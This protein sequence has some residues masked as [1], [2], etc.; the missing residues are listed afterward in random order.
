MNSV[1]LVGGFFGR[2][3]AFHQFDVEAER[4]QF[5]DENVER[6]RHTR[7]NARLALDDGLVD[8]RAAINVVGLCRKQ[9]LQ[10][11]RGAVS[12]ERPNFHFAEALAAELRLAAERLLRDERVRANAAG[13]DFVVDKVR[14]LEHVDVADGNRL[15][16]HVT[17]HAV[18]QIDFAGMRQARNFEQVA[19]FRF[20]RTVENGRG[21]RNSVLEAFGD[22]EQF[23]VV[24]L[25]DGL[26]N[27]GFGED[28]LEPAANGFGANFLAEKALQAIAEFLAGPAEVRFENLTDV[29]TRR[30][31]ERIQ[32]DFDGS[33]VGHI[34]H[35]FI[36]HDARDD[37][38][39]TVTAGH[40]IADGELALHGD[41]DLDE[42]EYA[43]R[44]FIALLELFLALFGDLAQHVNLA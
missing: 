26:I 33:A 15:I 39:V 6:F 21:E 36:G 38:L 34:R 14:K 3:L 17:R 35:I 42:L 2:L 16:E 29:H 13:V 44:Q 22:F 1:L 31:A 9:F 7:L 27:R 10:D 23:L 40:F 12:L 20:A 25:G 30:N 28:F 18:E 37:A 43:W 8:F 41:I 24:K 5:P 4:L 11:V 19:N 32:N